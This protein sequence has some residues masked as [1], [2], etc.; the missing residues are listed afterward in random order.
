[1]GAGFFLLVR[2][3]A[4]RVR[5]ET[6]SNVLSLPTCVGVRLFTSLARRVQVPFSYNAGYILRAS[7]PSIVIL[8]SRLSG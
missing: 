4:G 7:I 3:C 1:M 6:P 2:D 5:K 8:Q